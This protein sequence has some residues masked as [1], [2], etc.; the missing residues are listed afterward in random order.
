M[1]ATFFC[2]F[3]KQL[4]NGFPHSTDSEISHSPALSEVY[5]SLKTLPWLSPSKPEEQGCVQAMKNGTDI[6][7]PWEKR[8]S[9]D[10]RE[11]REG[12]GFKS[13]GGEKRGIR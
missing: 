11:K 1:N 10:H 9:K 13:T 3:R 6:S 8:K 12:E 7:T 5:S 2:V 4:E